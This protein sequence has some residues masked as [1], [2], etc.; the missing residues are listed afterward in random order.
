MANFFE[1]LGN[2]ITN[3]GQKVYD[4]TSG[5]AGKAVDATKSAGHKAKLKSD[6]NSEN[7]DLNKIFQDI[8]RYYFDKFRACPDEMIAQQFN[9]ANQKLANIANMEAE[10][11]AMET[12]DNNVSNQQYQQPYQGQ[13]QPDMYAQQAQPVSPDMSAQPQ[14][15][16]PDMSAQGQNVMPGV[17][18]MDNG[19]PDAG[20]VTPVAP[21]VAPVT[22]IA[23]DAP[24]DDT[25]VE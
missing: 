8:G 24:A 19:M 21:E 3:T 9:A 7:Y 13:P 18:P 16:S 5:I 20:I 11:R 4:K 10:L 17:V 23:P 12:Q 25:T 14:P 1:K 15:V 22:P 2:S 6:I